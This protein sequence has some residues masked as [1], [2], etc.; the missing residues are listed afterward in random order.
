[1]RLLKITQ[2]KLELISMIENIRRNNLEIE[3]KNH[4]IKRICDYPVYRIKKIPIVS[5]YFLRCSFSLLAK[6]MKI[7]PIMRFHQNPSDSQKLRV[8]SPSIENDWG[9]EFSYTLLRRNNWYRH[10]EKLS[11]NID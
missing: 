11:G 9:N 4:Q 3:K 8:T 5:K 2:D 1:M 6:E 10:L 7:K